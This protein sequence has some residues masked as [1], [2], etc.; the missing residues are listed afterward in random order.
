[1]EI[2]AAMVMALREKT[3]LPMMDCKRA[4][5][6][7]KGDEKAALEWLRAKGLKVQEKLVGREASQGR[8][9]CYLAADR[10]AAG[11]VELRC[12]TAPV[13]NTD[14]FIKLASMIARHAAAADAPRPDTIRNLA[15]L[16]DP[17]RRLGDAIDDVVNRIRE[18]IFV[19]RVD[20]LT[21]ATAAYVHF[22]GQSGAAVVLSGP[23]PAELATG[24][25]MHVTAMRPRVA[26]REDVPAQEVE[27]ERQRFAAEITGK[28]PQ[29]VDKIVGGKLDRWF[30]EFVLLE[31]PYVKD[32]KKT[33]AQAL[34]EVSPELTV[35]RFV[36]YRVG[37][38]A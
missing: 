25:C 5:M 8:V 28:P 35:K 20:K 38:P 13:A 19:A 27:R 10:S 36:R 33:V 29:I 14:D 9:A 32:D 34:K 6:E 30:S 37:E 15:L 26:R 11:I 7:S 23:C 18:N 22:D 2:T 31:Q 12:E 21:G 24:V 4:L 17:R 3:G 16:D 1:M